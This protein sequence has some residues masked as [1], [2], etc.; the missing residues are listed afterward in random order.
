M[1]MAEYKSSREILKQSKDNLNK[2]SKGLFS[3]IK[4]RLSIDIL[5]SEE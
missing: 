1:E 5:N 4:N 2:F 3:N